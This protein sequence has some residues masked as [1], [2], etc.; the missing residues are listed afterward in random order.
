DWEYYHSIDNKV[1]LKEIK[2]SR[3]D[4]VEYL[5]VIMTINDH[6][7]GNIAK[8]YGISKNPSTHNYIFVTELFD[9]DLNKFLTETFWDLGW[10]QKINILDS[11]TCGLRSL[12]EKS[13]VHSGNIS[14]STKH[15]KLEDSIVDNDVMHQL[16]IADENQRNTS[17][18]QKQELFELLSYSNKLHPQSCYIGRYIHT[19]HGL[20]DLL[21][22]IKSGNSSD[23]NLLKPNESIILK[24]NSY[25]TVLKN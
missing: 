19:L 25:D 1:A 12:H 23:P 24:S 3:H 10:E 4:I 11:I 13:L 20:Q 22:E 2:D 9:G 5:K 8:Y 15:E 21:E 14:N 18:S 16:K 6:D 17:K 7:N